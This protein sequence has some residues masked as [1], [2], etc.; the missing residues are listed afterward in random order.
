[1][2]I[3]KNSMIINAGEGVEKG[4]HAYMA[5][6]AENSPQGEQYGGSLKTESRTTVWHSSATPGPIPGEKFNSKNTLTPVFTVK[7]NGSL[8]GVKSGKG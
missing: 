8:L 6:G 7:T 3:I 4:E 1:M 2:V 5:S